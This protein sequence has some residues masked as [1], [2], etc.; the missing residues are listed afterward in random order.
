MDRNG[1]L[2]TMALSCP[3][4]LVERAVPGFEMFA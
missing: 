1:Y 4:E 3:G 2:H